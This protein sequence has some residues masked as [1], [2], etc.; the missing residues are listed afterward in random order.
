MKRYIAFMAALATLPALP[1]LA[2]PA[3]SSNDQAFVQ[4]AAIG[5]MAE[6]EEGQIAASKAQATDVK[7]FGQRMIAD[8]TRNNQELMS[9][10][11]QKGVTTPPTLDTKHA[12]EAATL[13]KESGG[14]FD[15]AYIRDQVAG[16]QQMA[17]MMRTEMHKGTD[18]DLKAFAQKTLPVVQEHLKMAQQLQGKT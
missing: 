8:H 3:L 5:G 14:A 18:P 9:L 15:S 17:Q 10:A 4:Q 13:K 12:Q 16:H 11:R 2:A 1:G 7:Q 6:V